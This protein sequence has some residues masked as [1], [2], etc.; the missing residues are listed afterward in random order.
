M[1]HHHWHGGW[2]QAAV[3]AVQYDVGNGGQTGR[4]RDAAGASA[5]DPARVKTPTL[6]V[7]VE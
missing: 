1:S 3:Q 5:L 2:P 4:S 6:A 7:G